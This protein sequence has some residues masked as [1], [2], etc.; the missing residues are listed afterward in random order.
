MAVLPF[1]SV[2]EAV[3]LRIALGMA[4]EI[5]AALSRFRAPRLIA[6]ATFWDGLGPASDVR[7]RCRAYHLDYI[8]EGTICVLDDRV[9]VDVILS[10]VVLDFDVVWRGS[11]EGRL[12]D[13][14]SLQSRIAFDMVTQVDPELF[15]RGAASEPSTGTEV[16]A[17]HQSVLAA[18]Q[19]IYRL[20]RLPFMAARDLL[21][22]AIELDP[23]YAAAHGWMAYWSIIAA[24]LGWVENPQAVATLA[25]TSAERA[26]VLDPFNARA[27]AV[28]GHVK[29]YLMHD[30]PS[31]LHLHARAIELNPNLPIAWTVSAWSRIYNGEHTTAVRHAMM[32]RSLSPR[33]PHIWFAEHAM[34]MAQLFNRNL[35]EAEMLSEALLQRHPS[36]VAALNSRLAILGHL[37]WKDEASHCLTRLR[38][39]D[40]NVTVDKISSRVP[41]RPEDMIFYMEGLERAGVPRR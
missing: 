41:L 32:S 38:K 26:V 2:G 40:P 3:G 8:I 28:A 36:H 37:G 20:D 4:E 14:F 30:V 11:F 9:S 25:G 1:R 6:T 18:I 19:A 7:A 22:R 33:D 23:D 17:A 31:A 39:F 5:S 27:L 24:A 21:A 12:N 35:E 34:V 15:H 10:D 13:L 16:A 29:G